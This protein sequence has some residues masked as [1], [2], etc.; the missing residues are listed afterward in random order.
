MPHFNRSA[1]I[2]ESIRSVEDQTYKNWELIIVDDGSDETEL[3]KIKHYGSIPGIRLICA[4]N[5]TKG[6]AACRNLGFRLATG[7]Y[8]VFLDSDDVLEPFCLAQ[9]LAVITKDPGLD[10]AVFL[11]Y[12]WRP[13][14][15]SNPVF[16]KPLKNKE[17]AIDWF[18]KMDPPWQTMAPIWKKETLVKLNGFDA[19]LIY[20]EDPDLH[21][22]AL[23]DPSLKVS[24]NYDLPADSYYRLG[25]M[26]IDKSSTFYHLSIISRFAFLEKLLTFLKEEQNG[27]EDSFSKCKRSIRTGFYNFVRD[28]LIYRIGEY[29]AQFDASLKKMGSYDILTW[30]DIYKLKALR[31]VF[32]SKSRLVSMLKLRGLLYKALLN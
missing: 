29:N 12:A 17:E 9:R 18:F 3:E 32:L 26:D 11:Q 6:A 19:S 27:D 21:L 20:M 16:N 31:N 2:A 15:S 30:W 5:E 10:W 1:L 25:N 28:F 24:F 8:I 13:G 14:R 4:N 7:K 22:R 23:L